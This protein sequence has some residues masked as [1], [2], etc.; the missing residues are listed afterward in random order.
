MT[1]YF[2]LM[3]FISLTN[4]LTKWYI[5][6]R[7]L[8]NYLLQ[9]VLVYCADDP[10]VNAQVKKI[11]NNIKLKNKNE[12]L[13]PQKRRETYMK[14]WQKIFELLKTSRSLRAHCSYIPIKILM[15]NLD[16]MIKPKL[17]IELFQLA[18]DKHL[19]KKFF[20]NY[21]GLKSCKDFETIQ[22]NQIDSEYVQLQ[23]PKRP[24]Y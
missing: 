8:E 23:K 6:M 7:D 2:Y 3:I 22:L 21:F 20:L 4:F 11:L 24:E 18:A 5:V 15:M 17:Q 14:Y 10:D 13:S 1:K 9:F 12:T 16:R 19:D